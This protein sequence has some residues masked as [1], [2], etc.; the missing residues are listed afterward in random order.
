M[1]SS[2]EADFTIQFKDGSFQNNDAKAVF[3]K[4]SQTQVF[5]G[6]GGI[7]RFTSGAPLP[8]VGSSSASTANTEGSSG[9]G[10]WG[11]FTGIAYLGFEKAGNR[12]WL[13]LDH[14]AGTPD[15]SVEVLS[16]AYGSEGEI[17][18]AGVVPEPAHSAALCALLA[19]TA[20]CA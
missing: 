1:E 6:E 18:K 15:G 7:A 16:Y 17:T 9:N 10:P 13:E 20:A 11:G 8:T 4:Q 12:G 14:Q 3:Q 2:P 5:T 19:G